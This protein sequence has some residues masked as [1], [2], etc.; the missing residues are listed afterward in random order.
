MQIE[1]LVL[2][3]VCAN[4]YIV[5]DEKTNEAAVIDCGE[6]TQELEN[7]L[8]GK[9]LKYILLTHGHYDHILGVYDLKMSHPEAKIVAHNDEAYK[10][11]DELPSFA[12]EMMP[13]VQK[14]VPADIIV[15][16]GDKLTVGEIEFTVMHTPGH[17]KGGVCYFA[18]S[19]RT[20]FTGDTLFCLTVG[21]TDFFD[22]SEEEMLESIT[23]LYNMEGDYDIYPGHNRA[24]TMEYEK[25]R[26]R[27]MR[28][29]R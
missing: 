2:G 11:V 20:I 24:T 15:G 4:C 17:S 13:G 18:E 28:R 9:K 7:K 25:R 6:Y 3:P 22:S 16:E 19:E 27:Y 10:L 23:R 29:F 12:H 14:Y 8:E 1:T 5:T 21:R 26:N